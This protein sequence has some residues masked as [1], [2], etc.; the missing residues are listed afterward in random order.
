MVR[1]DEPGPGSEGERLLLQ[2]PLGGLLDATAVA[3]S[4]PAS[5]MGPSCQSQS[6]FSRRRV[7]AASGPGHDGPYESDPKACQFSPPPPKIRIPEVHQ[8]DDGV[9]CA[10]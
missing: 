3:L 4:A 6:D 9:G 8:P 5:V 2:L 7:S 10:R 1:S